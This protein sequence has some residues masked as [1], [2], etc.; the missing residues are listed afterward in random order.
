MDTNVRRKGICLA[1]RCVCCCSPSLETLEHLFIGSDLAI[2]IY[3]FFV[4]KFQKRREISSVTDLIN[5]WMHGISNRSQLG[6][7]IRGSISVMLWEFWKHRCK[8]KLEGGGSNPLAVIQATLQQLQQVNNLQDPMRHITQWERNILEMLVI[9]IKSVP[10]WQG[11]WVSWQEPHHPGLKLNADGS[12]R[13]GATTGGGVVRDSN[14]E[15]MLGFSVKYSHS[16]VF[17]AE[18]DSIVHGLCMCYE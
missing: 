13:C 18:L 17:Q 11:K 7:L 16:D 14:G 3:S 10:F 4:D 6:N 5:S 2:A 9:Q 8:L 15:F 1:S 12:R